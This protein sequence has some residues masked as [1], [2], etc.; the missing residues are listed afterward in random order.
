MAQRELG[1][2]SAWPSLHTCFLIIETTHVL[3]LAFSVGTVIW[4]D[5]SCLAV[6]APSDG[7]VRFQSA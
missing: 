7:V 4:F 3:A 6:D 1:W 2:F 5:V